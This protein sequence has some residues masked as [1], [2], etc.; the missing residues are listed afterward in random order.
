MEESK[1]FAYVWRFGCPYCDSWQD[2]KTTINR[3]RYSKDYNNFRE[4]WECTC[5]G[6]EFLAIHE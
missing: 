6:K 2:I 4:V 1:G 5:C 3:F